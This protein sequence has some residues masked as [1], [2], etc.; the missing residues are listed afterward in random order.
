MLGFPDYILKLAFVDYLGSNQVEFGGSNDSQI[1]FW[2]YSKTILFITRI[3][4]GRSRYPNRSRGHINL[5][6]GFIVLFAY[7]WRDT[8]RLCVLS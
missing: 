8:W 5:L 4:R 2:H 3:C 7:G 6:L 1:R